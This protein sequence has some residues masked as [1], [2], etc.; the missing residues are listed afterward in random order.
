MYSGNDA[1]SQPA[2]LADVLLHES[3]VP[4]FRRRL[5]ATPPVVKP[6]LETHVQFK[7][8]VAKVVKEANKHGKWDRLC[9]EY[10]ARIDAL[11]EKEGDRLRQ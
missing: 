10:P 7:A 11:I 6:W 5:T 4:T 3:A 9:C 8:R 2:D 1:S